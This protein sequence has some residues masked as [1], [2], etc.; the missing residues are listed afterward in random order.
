M[1][2]PARYQPPLPS[3]RFIRAEPLGDEAT[4]LDVLFVGGGPAGLAGAI[5]LAKLIK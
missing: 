1:I 3:T 5:Q 4:P 2:L